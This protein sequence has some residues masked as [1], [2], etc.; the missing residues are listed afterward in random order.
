MTKKLPIFFSKLRTA[1]G[2]RLIMRELSPSSFKVSNSVASLNRGNGKADPITVILCPYA[3]NMLA[4]SGRLIAADF[5][6]YGIVSV[7]K[8]PAKSELDSKGDDGW[9]GNQRRELF[10]D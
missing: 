2:V 7:S 8:A 5:N 6:L 9:K 10:I 1:P 4:T 3:F